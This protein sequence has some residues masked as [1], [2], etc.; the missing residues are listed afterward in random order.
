M[1]VNKEFVLTEAL[2]RLRRLKAKKQAAINVRDLELKELLKP[3]KPKMEKVEKKH[4]GAIEENDEKIA[5][6]QERITEVIIKEV[7]AT[8][9]GDEPGENGK[10]MGAVYVKP[11]VNWLHD[12][13]EGMRIA[14]PDLDWD[15]VRTEAE[16]GTVQFKEL[17]PDE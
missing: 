4:A 8:S 16:F 5:K 10:V 3:L 14:L 2:D 6:L 12:K 15:S 7:K 11:K 17:K 13:L 1:A 9:R